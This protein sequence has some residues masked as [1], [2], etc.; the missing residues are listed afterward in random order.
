MT[1]PGLF[2][3]IFALYQTV[4]SAGV[5]EY[6]QKQTKI[7][8]RR[9]IYSPQVVLWLMM[10]QRLHAAG[11]LS[12]AV[13]LLIQ[14]A[15]EPLLQ[16]CE[17]RRKGRISSRT[18]GYCQ[19]RCKLPVLLCTQVSREIN[20]RL[21]QMLCP[22]NPDGPRAYLLD[23]SSLELEHSPELL[24][25]YPPAKNQHGTSHWP[26]L[27]MLVLHELESG[28]AEEPQWGPM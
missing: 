21:G 15:A 4:L 13:Q 28:L 23:G 12:A 11:T 25:T 14:G 1:S 7:R 16:D 2:S 6:F 8:I 24:R 20:E 26:V 9:S 18:G 5:I 3:D 19:A 27:R 17:R 10:L 22:Q